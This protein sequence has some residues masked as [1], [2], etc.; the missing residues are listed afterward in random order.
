MST[1]AQVA[2]IPLFK[3]ISPKELQAMAGCLDMHKRSFERGEI[4][5]LTDQH[6]SYVGVV[7]DGSVQMTHEDID[8]NRTLLAALGPGELVG[9]TF[10]CGAQRNSKVTFQAEEAS[11]LVFMAFDRV[12]H[13]CNRVCRFHQRLASNMVEQ[14]CAKNVQLMD[15]IEVSSRKTLRDKIRAYL[16]NLSQKQNS[17][18]VKLPLTRTAL[19]EYLDANR[20]ALTRELGRMQ[21]EG[22]L[23]ISGR[24]IRIC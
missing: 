1:E 14:I 3:G 11:T 23:E 6:I 8:G 21:D 13:S 5:Y 19:A 7:I 22:I 2:D 10:A 24:S 20:S 9:E 18:T 15:K 16:S 4:V 17:H 12:L